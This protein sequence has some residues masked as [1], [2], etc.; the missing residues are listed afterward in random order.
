MKYERTESSVRGVAEPAT[1]GCNV[2]CRISDAPGYLTALNVRW[3]IPR[4][5]TRHSIDDTQEANGLGLSGPCVMEQYVSLLTQE[6][7]LRTALIM[8]K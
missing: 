1:F 4:V 2:I 3:R 5:L 7:Q 6:C 8:C